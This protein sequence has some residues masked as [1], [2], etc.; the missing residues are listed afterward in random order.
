MSTMV[1]V[2]ARLM[3][4]LRQKPWAARRTEKARKESIGPQYLRW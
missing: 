1:T 2:A 4:R 3:T